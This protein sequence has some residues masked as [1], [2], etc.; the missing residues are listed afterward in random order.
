MSRVQAHA[1]AATG[2]GAPALIRPS[3]TFSREREKGHARTTPSPMRSVGEGARRA[4]EGP[5]GS[6]GGGHRCWRTGPHP[7]LRATFSR[8]REKGHARTTPLP[9]AAWERVPEGRV[10]ARATARVAATGAGAPALIRRFAPPSPA[11]GRRVEEK[12]SLTRCRRKKDECYCPNTTRPSQMVIR[13]R[14]VLIASGSV[15]S[16]FP[17]STVTS[18]RRPGFSTPV[19]PSMKPACAPST[20]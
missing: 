2:A 18:A 8:R 15:L 17:A 14:M 1:V 19:L 10:R 4:G 3:A 13:G 9:C 11:S 16:R 5:S 20:V 12:S 7:A 6:E